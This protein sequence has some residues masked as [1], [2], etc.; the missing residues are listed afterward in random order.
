M[1][2]MYID[3]SGLSLFAATASVAYDC[4]CSFCLCIFASLFDQF[5]CVCK[6]NFTAIAV[7]SSLLNLLAIQCICVWIIYTIFDLEYIIHSFVSCFSEVKS[8]VISTIFNILI[9]VA[10]LCVYCCSIAR[11]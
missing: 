4:C 7:F 10:V 1:F 9:C 5:L 6:R 8:C 2:F 3:L 11:E